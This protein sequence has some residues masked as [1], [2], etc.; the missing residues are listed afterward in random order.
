[1][2]WFPWRRSSAPSDWQ[3]VTLAGVP[4]VPRMTHADELKYF[5]WCCAK[6]HRR[7][8][9]V[10][11]LGP[12]IGG[13]TVAMAAGLRESNDPRAKLVTI[14]WFQWEQWAIG[15]YAQ[16]AV[17]GLSDEQR[18]SLS[19]QDL[20]PKVGHS[21]LPIFHAYTRPFAS[22]IEVV[23]VDIAKYQWTGEPIDVLMIDAAKS[24]PVFDQIVGQFFPSL[25]D[26]ASVIHQDYKH[27]Y[28]YWLHIVTERML[29][30]GVLSWAENVHERSTQ[31]FRFVKRSGF[32]PSDYMQA[33]FDVRESERLLRQAID[34]YESPTER[35][36]ITS[37]YI[38]FLREQGQAERARQIFA[39]A[40]AAGPY[41]EGV[42]LHEFLAHNPAEWARRS[43]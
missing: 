24:W 40:L 9:R 15:V 1:M 6:R 21:F 23:D 43:A 35:L 34:R 19:P 13:S 41:E 4:D 12:F 28:C 17:N 7:G 18:A 20:A 42:F 10:V 37:A 38:R 31:G 8:R 26:G 2:N 30:R 3:A 33:A 27:W 36:A 25:V 39:S 14:D 11:E 29:E 32:K 16:N 5:C 22:S